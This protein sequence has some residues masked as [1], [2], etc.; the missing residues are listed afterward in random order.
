MRTSFHILLCIYFLL[1]S[2]GNKRNNNSKVSSLKFNL[3]QSEDATE[4]SKEK[5]PN[6]IYCSQVKYHNPHTETNSTYTLTVVVFSNEV[7]RINFPSGGWMDEDHFS[8]AVLDESGY[9]TFTSD[10]GYK[11]QIQITGN[12]PDCFT[13]SVLRAKQCRGTTAVRNPCKNMTDNTNG[14]CWKH[15]NQK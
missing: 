14:L 7:T 5:Y 6:G 12:E 2:C 15:Q 9:T 3:L 11:Y 10:K 1:F 13:D 4:V 8:G